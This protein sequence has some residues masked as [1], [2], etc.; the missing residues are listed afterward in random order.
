[1]F[2]ANWKASCAVLLGGALAIAGDPRHGVLEPRR[3]LA[4]EVPAGGI[5]EVT[6]D[7]ILVAFWQGVQS[8]RGSTYAVILS[9]DT[10]ARQL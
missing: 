4:P 9:K 1:M 10:A 8:G 2:A 6:R 3:A 7:R 5:I